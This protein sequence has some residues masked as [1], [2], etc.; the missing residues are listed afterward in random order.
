MISREEI[1][2]KAYISV[3]GDLVRRSFPLRIVG[4]KDVDICKKKT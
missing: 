3:Y 1:K 2:V 4:E